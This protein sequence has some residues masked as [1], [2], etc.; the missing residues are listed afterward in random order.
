MHLPS[1]PTQHNTASS[2]PEWFSHSN[3]GRVTF[4]EGARSLFNFTL[5]SG[6][7]HST[8]LRSNSVWV[9]RWN[10][11]SY[12]VARRP[13]EVVDS[14]FLPRSFFLQ[15][16]LAKHLLPSRHCSV[17]ADAI[18]PPIIVRSQTRSDSQWIC[19]ITADA[20]FLSGPV[21]LGWRSKSPGSV[22]IRR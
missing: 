20:A 7:P 12:L 3:G 11:R 1:E 9:R 4:F 13:T 2:Y 16:Q 5:Q 17:A 10:L 14:A 22:F 6:G 19:G 21:H 15:A 8:F 18:L